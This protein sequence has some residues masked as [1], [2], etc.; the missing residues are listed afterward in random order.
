MMKRGK[1]KERAEV[2]VVELAV[3]VGMV[4]VTEMVEKAVAVTYCFMDDLAEW[5]KRKFGAQ[6]SNSAPTRDD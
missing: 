6:P 2:K 5:F 4:V 3:V 1:R